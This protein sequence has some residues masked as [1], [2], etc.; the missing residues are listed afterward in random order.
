M[1]YESKSDFFFSFLR[2]AAE[3]DEKWYKK[4]PSESTREY[5]TL[6]HKVYG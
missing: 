6:N 1:I 2:S 5:I 4:H 3:L